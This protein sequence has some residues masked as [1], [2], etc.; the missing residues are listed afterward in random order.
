M[1]ENGHLLFVLHIFNE[2]KTNA[3]VYWLIVMSLGGPPK[4][5]AATTQFPGRFRPNQQIGLLIVMSLGGGIKRNGQ[6]CPHGAKMTP[7]AYPSEPQNPFKLPGYQ[8]GI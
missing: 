8:Y 7:V 5:K 3:P 1:T 4:N 2:H 6:N